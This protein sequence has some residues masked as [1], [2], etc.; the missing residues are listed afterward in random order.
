MQQTQWGPPTAGIVAAGILGLVMAV[1]VVTLV[2]DPPGRAL[3]GLAAA[4]LV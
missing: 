3:V 2:T 4:G 1:G